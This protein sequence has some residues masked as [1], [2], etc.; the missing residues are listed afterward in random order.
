L[1]GGNLECSSVDGAGATFSIS[2][3]RKATCGDVLGADS[4]RR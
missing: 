4:S 1:H 2:L 3:P